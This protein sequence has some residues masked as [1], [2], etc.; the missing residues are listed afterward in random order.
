[1]FTKMRQNAKKSQ[2]VTHYP[3]LSFGFYLVTQGRR[4]M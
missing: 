1:M 3:V 4:R 2:K